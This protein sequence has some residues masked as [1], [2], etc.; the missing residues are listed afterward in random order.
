VHRTG[1]E[2]GEARYL[3]DADALRELE[4]SAA[5]RKPNYAE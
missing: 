5:R 4:V 2:A 3:A 1:T